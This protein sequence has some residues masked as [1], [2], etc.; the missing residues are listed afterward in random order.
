MVKLNSNL[1]FVFARI[2]SQCRHLGCR[3]CSAAAAHSAACPP[4]GR[5]VPAGAHGI[6]GFRNRNR[7][8]PFEIK[9]D[10]VKF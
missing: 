2:A 3:R 6:H 1:P 7:Q 10:I 8:R 4:A 5:Q 9:Q